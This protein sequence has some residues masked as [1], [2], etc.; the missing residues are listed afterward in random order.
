MERACEADKSIGDSDFCCLG[1]GVI[2]NIV[3]FL[4]SRCP[5]L[6]VIS[7][8]LK[9]DALPGRLVGTMCGGS[10]GH[11]G[12]NNHQGFWEDANCV[13]MTI[14]RNKFNKFC[15][16]S[17]HVSLVLACFAWDSVTATRHPMG[18]LVGDSGLCMAVVGEGA[19]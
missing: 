7:S 6:F 13:G 18:K 3:L 17:C 2:C 14:V 4:L 9:C 15:R 12:K 11:R 10:A 19:C 8:M 16:V 5:C 1:K